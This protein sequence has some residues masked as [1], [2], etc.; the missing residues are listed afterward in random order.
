MDPKDYGIPWAFYKNIYKKSFLDENNVRFPPFKRGVDPVFLAKALA[1]AS[2]IYTVPVDLYGYNWSIGGGFNNKLFDYSFKKNHLI[3]FK[4][5]FDILENAGFNKVAHRFKKE[6]ITYL[7]H[8]GN[9]NDLELF[10]LVHEVF[11]EDERYFNDYS[12]EFM[13][14]KIKLI[15]NNINNQEFFVYAKNTLSEIPIWENDLLTNSIIREIFV[16]LSS[17]S[18]EEYELNIHKF[19]INEAS[20]NDLT[21]SKEIFNPEFEV[22]ELSESESS[23]IEG[24][25]SLKGNLTSLIENNERLKLKIY[26]LTED[27]KYLKKEVNELTELKEKD[28]PSKGS[29]IKKT[30]KLGK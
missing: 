20:G 2:K 13:L 3:A 25:N 9:E 14:Y 7:T 18:F 26:K 11:G 16:V 4:S 30:L 5:S 6:V 21:A 24:R 17:N 1:E 23:L 22:Q 8:F 27:N 15:L 19:I 10:N 12:N 28:S 29:K